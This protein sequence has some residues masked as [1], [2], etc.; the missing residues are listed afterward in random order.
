[1]SLWLRESGL[2]LEVIT[3]FALAGLTY[4]LK[5]FWAPLVDRTRIPD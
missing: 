2:S 5:F 1:L 4:A 3:F